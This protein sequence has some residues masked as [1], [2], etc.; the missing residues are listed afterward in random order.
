M[1]G[2]D[3]GK[4]EYLMLAILP[5][6]DRWSIG[7]GMADSHPYLVDL[8]SSP[9]HQGLRGAI[10]QLNFSDPPGHFLGWVKPGVK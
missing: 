7:A 9:L 10:L 8:V 1:L 3:G 5:Q 2:E 4:T 6:P